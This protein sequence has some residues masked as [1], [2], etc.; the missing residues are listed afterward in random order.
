MGKVQSKIERRYNAAATCERFDCACRHFRVFTRDSFRQI[1]VLL[2][3][4][5]RTR[6]LQTHY[7]A[8]PPDCP[9]MGGREPTG[10]DA[11]KSANNCE[12]GRNVGRIL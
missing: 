1:F 3:N 5:Y 8:V 2:G 10:E 11:I 7:I 12:F 4:S 6:S 9:D